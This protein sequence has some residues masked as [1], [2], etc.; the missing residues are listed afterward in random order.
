MKK[1]K[2]ITALILASLTLCALLCA[3]KGN[4][5]PPP[6]DTTNAPAA[7]TAPDTTAAPADTAAPDP[8][9]GTAEELLRR[10]CLVLKDAPDAS[11][12]KLANIFT[13]HPYLDG[14]ELYT[15]AGE[16]TKYSDYN[17]IGLKSDFTIPEYSKFAA[18]NAPMYGDKKIPFACSIFELN[19]GADAAAFAAAL[20]EN[21]DPAS[22]GE[23]ITGTECLAAA[24][25]KYVFFVIC[26]EDLKNSYDPAKPESITSVLNRLR[27]EAELYNT[28]VMAMD[29]D[30]ESNFRFFGLK[31]SL[32]LV[33]KGGAVAEPAVGGGFSVVLVRVKDKKDVSTVANEM[34]G[35]LDP[36][37]WICM[38][39]ETTQVET[40]GNYVLGIMGSKDECQKIAD[41]FKALSL[42]E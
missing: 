34:A 35:G 31:D 32:A 9:L 42:P 5:V 12:E 22:L 25:G 30:D 18:I 21:A 4:N 41:I 29:A 17:I 14:I 10:F 16:R 3:C 33:E 37:K 24:E 2:R 27:I 39:A 8:S 23:N 28:S 15:S 19:D 36:G 1:T 7:T 40:N 38:C 11:I 13:L 6:A 20:K 26:P